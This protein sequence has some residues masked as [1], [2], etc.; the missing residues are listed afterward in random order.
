[1]YI[2]KSGGEL[3]FPG[4]ERTRSALGPTGCAEGLESTAKGDVRGPKKAGFK[5]VNYYHC[6]IN[7]SNFFKAIK[8][9]KGY[10]MLIPP[11]VVPQPL[12]IIRENIKICLRY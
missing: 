12:G 11:K 9:C 4:K 5:L 2:M 6:Q 8:D 1:M 10:C 7:F 3:S